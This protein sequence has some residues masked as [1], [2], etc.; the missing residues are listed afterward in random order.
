MKRLSTVFS[1]RRALTISACALMASGVAVRA[2]TPKPTPIVGALAHRAELQRAADALRRWQ[3]TAPPSI[4]DLRRVFPSEDARVIQRSD[5]AKQKTAGSDW[6]RRID[7]IEYSN[8]AQ[9]VQRRDLRA[10]EAIVQSR[11]RAL[12][13]WTRSP[14]RSHDAQKIVKDLANSGAIS[15]VA[16]TWQT[17]WQ[18]AKDAISAFFRRLTNWRPPVANT[19]KITGNPQWIKFFFAS[20]LAALLVV[21][22][23]WLWKTFGGRFGN[24]GARREVRFGEGEEELLLLPPDELR[25]RADRLAS[26]GDFAQALRHRFVAIL[27]TLD[28]Q[29]VWRYDTRRT[30]WEHIAALRKKRETKALV[31]PLSSLTYRFDRVRYGEMSCTQPDWTQFASDANDVESQTSSTRDVAKK[32][33]SSATE[34][35]V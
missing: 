29:K 17:W 9:R 34:V 15:T 27:L 18:N 32:A 12:D 10:L 19:P 35:T 14:Y 16:P 25:L 4:K 2:Q 21:I 31:A 23:W 3:K 5:G 11:L 30:N 1:L 24:R 26:Q 20:T 13:G 28:S 7:D 6:A 22:A 8:N 33:A